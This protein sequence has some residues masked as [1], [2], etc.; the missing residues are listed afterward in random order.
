MRLDS[1]FFPQVVS[2]FYM[3]QEIILLSY[4]QDCKNDKERRLHNVDVRHDD[5]RSSEGHLI[6]SGFTVEDHNTTQDTY[7]KPAII[8]DVPSSL[9]SKH[10]SSDP[11]IEIPPSDSSQTNDDTRRSEGHLI[12]SG[13][14]VEDHNS[15]QD[16]HEEPAIIPDVPSSLHSRHLSSDPFIEIPPS[17][18][19]QTN[20]DT[21]RSEGH[22]ISS[23]FTVEDHNGTQDAYEKPAIIPDV[24]SALHSKHLSADPFIEVPPSD[25]SQTNKQHNIYGRAVEEETAATGKK[26]YSCSECGNCFN[27]KSNLVSHQRIH[28]GEKPFSC[29]ECGNCFTQKSNLVKHQRIHTG[30]KPFFCSECGKCF[31]QKPHLVRHQRIHTG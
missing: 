19:S 7:E 22:L 15:T 14:T 12:S 8:P 13:F 27:K 9:P 5:T 28:T 26:S 24:P 31:T 17:D 30:E 29:S 2:M 20:D 23:G 16:T 3:E 4:Y 25:S 10:L 1:S 21:R 18:S 11:F 6:S